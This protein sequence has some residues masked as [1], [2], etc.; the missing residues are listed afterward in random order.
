MIMNLKNNYLIN[1]MQSIFIAIYFLFPP[2]CFDE[3]LK[4]TKI[5]QNNF[6]DG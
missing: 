3:H 6:E 5:L 4:N 1:Y 2:F